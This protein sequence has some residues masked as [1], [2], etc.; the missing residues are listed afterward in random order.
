MREARHPL[1]DA[2]YR[3]RLHAGRPVKRKPLGAAPKGVS[4]HIVINARAKSP[5]PERVEAAVAV[6]KQSVETVAVPEKLHPL[7]AKTLAAARKAKPDRNDAIIGLGAKFFRLRA[8]L[9]TLDR[10]G[11][12][13]NALVYKALARG[14]RFEAGRE[15]L[16]MIVDDEAIGFVVC[17]T[18]RRSIHV[19]TKRRDAAARAAG[20]PAIAMIGT[21]GT[22]AHSPL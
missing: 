7:V 19:A 5:A 20:M 13:L 17:Q 4:D 16:E 21:T 6:A 8:H 12:F 10:V 3:G 11:I 1:P 18:I 15:G 2:T 9:D 14:N 22:S